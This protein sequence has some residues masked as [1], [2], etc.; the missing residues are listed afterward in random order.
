MIGKNNDGRDESSS[1]VT[2]I[3]GH[4][5]LVAATYRELGVD[6]LIDEK[7]PKKRNHNIT[8]SV[9]VLA[10]ILNGLGFVGQR[11]YLFPEFF[12][13]ISYEKLY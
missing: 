2:K 5:G 11:L 12:M 8:H 4:L 10:M 7:L 13:N 6:K 9:C 3:V 1:K